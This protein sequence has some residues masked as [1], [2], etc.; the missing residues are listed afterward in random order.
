MAIGLLHHTEKYEHARS[1]KAFIPYTQ[2]EWLDAFG[3]YQHFGFC[4]WSGQHWTF[5]VKSARPNP[6]VNA[7]APRRRVAS[8]PSF[9]APVNLVR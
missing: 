2:P 3:F 8:P 4:L 6:S 9:V 1:I 5:V 7:D